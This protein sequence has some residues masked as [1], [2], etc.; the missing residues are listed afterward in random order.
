MYRTVV[1]SYRHG[2]GFYME[3]K[4]LFKIQTNEIAANPHNPRLIFDPHELD[5]L[6]KSIEKVGILVPLTV[7]KNEKSFPKAKYVLLD[8]ERR[9]RC[10]KEIGLQEIHAN[11]IDEP[12]D[13]TQ[14][15][16]FMFNIHHFRTEW[17]LFPT[18]LKLET[19]IKAMGTDQES[20]LSEFTGVKKT[21]IRRCK[22]L[23]WYPSKYRDVL[24]EKGGKI[25]TD[26]FIELYPIVY[27]LSQEEEYLYPH[28]TEKLVDALMNKFLSQKVITDVKE[29]RDIRRAMGY[30][31]RK[32]EMATFKKQLSSF[33]GTDKTGLEVFASPEINADKTYQNVI[34]YVSFL[35]ANLKELNP[36]M[37]SDL[38]LVEQLKNLNINIQ[39]LIDKIE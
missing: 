37:A 29:F 39:L 17:E 10:A 21:T 6:K 22:T 9:W 31:E 24:T 5:E 8:G 34:K 15:I 26:F 18:A 27:R 2:G 36:D 11:I 23:L 20:V 14:N 1:H 19:L 3:A 12:A 7:Y 38:S 30:Y 25:S 16:L 35:N 28:G 33:I 32:S 4:T 13:V